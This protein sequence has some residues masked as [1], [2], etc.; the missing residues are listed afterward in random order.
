MRILSVLSDEKI[1]HLSEIARKSGTMRSTARKHLERLK[2]EGAI[3][4][5][6]RGN[7]RLFMLREVT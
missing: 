6:R 4:E 3:D 2:E 1:T 7:L 5:L